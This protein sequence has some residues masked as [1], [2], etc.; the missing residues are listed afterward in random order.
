MPFYRSEAR[1]LSKNKKRQVERLQQ[2]KFR[3]QEGLFVAEGT[4]LVGDFIHAGMQPRFV[5]ATSIGIQQIAEITSDT[6]FCEVDE[7]ELKELSNLKTP[8]QVIAIFDKPSYN[9][10]IASTPKDLTLL[11]DR[12]QDPGN[13]GTII[14]TADWFG[15]E[16]II[17]S[18]TCVDAFAPK[19]VQATMGALARVAI[20]ETDLAKLLKDNFYGAQIPVY[21][22][23]MNGESIYST[24][25][26]QDAYVIMGN[27]GR[28]ISE[29]LW[30]FIT[31]KV[32]IPSYPLGR[33]TSES[34]NVAM[35]T[36][37]ICSE[38]RRRA[39]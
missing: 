36:S 4:K 13:M 8:T 20:V 10:D 6:E 7:R 38:I 29:E 21:G 32:S 33:T 19:V 27:E 35:A 31:K 1:M 37:V 11:L 28:G 16:R 22:T 3:D 12:I 25:L 18:D 5:V 17:C 2:K 23:F 39:I 15:I 34:L 24:D 14:R 26:Q 9:Q 30:P